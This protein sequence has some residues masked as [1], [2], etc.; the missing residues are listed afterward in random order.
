M[1]PSTQC[2]VDEF[3][4]QAYIEARAGLVNRFLEHFLVSRDAG[5]LAQAIRHLLFPGGKRFRPVLA[6]AAAEAVGGRAEQALPIAAAVELI[7]TY[8]LIHDD[9]PCMDD[10]DERRGQPTVHVAYGEAI[11]V[12]AGDA[13]Q[14]LAFEVL[15]QQRENVSAEALLATAHDLARAAGD[16]NL[17]GGQADDIVFG[18]DDFDA[19]R[20]ESV[21]R[22]K[23]A[24]LIAVAIVGGARLA[25]ADVLTLKRLQHFGECMGLAFQI[26]DDLLDEESEEACSSVRVLG[27]VAARSRCEALLAQAF[28]EIAE[29]GARGA[30]LRALAEFSVRRER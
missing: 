30:A 15:T 18:A 16:L 23:T 19:E 3:D 14:A 17:V 21:Q 20:L 7:H 9:L 4:L 22:R 24:A 2:S 12:L 8:S 29:L 1:T 25:G 27:V 13:L 6:L 10:D 26:A 28:D 5:V 11:A